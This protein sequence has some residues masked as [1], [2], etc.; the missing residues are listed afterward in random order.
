MLPLLVIPRY[1]H[2]AHGFSVGERQ[3]LSNAGVAGSQAD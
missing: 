3:D 1:V 2:L